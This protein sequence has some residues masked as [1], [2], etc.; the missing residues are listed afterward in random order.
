MIYE[1]LS[2]SKGGG[3]SDLTNKHSPSTSTREFYDYEGEGKGE[4]VDVRRDDSITYN[5]LILR[6]LFGRQRGVGGAGG[7]TPVFA[8]SFSLSKSTLFATQFV[9]SLLRTFGLTP[10]WEQ[11]A[12]ASAPG[13]VINSL[14]LIG[15]RSWDLSGGRSWD[16]GGVGHWDLGGG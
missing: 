6:G 5:C 12:A 11:D 7:G 3:L 14:K 15:G 16:L 13:Y 4:I 10:Q 1:L 2:A 8:K 9:T